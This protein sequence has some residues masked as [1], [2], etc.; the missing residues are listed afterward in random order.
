MFFQ[1]LL[2]SFNINNLAANAQ[3]QE[4]GAAP[5]PAPP[6]A[7][8]EGGVEAGAAGVVGAIQA[9]GLYEYSFLII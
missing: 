1:S 4:A 5:A 6:V 9:E 7:N 2:P 3:P 8:F